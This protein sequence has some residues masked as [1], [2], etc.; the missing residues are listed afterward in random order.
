[1]ER[2]KLETRTGN[3]GA[4]LVHTEA[5]KEIR[6]IEMYTIVAIRMYVKIETAVCCTMHSVFDPM[7]RPCLV[8][9]AKVDLGRLSTIQHADCERGTP[10]QDNPST[11]YMR[12]G[13]S[14][15][16]KS[17]QED[18]QGLESVYLLQQWI[19]ALCYSAFFEDMPPKMGPSR[20]NVGLCF[21]RE[22]SA[23]VFKGRI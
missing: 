22:V 13:G 18:I 1:M 11:R 19:S 20:S 12:W 9:M 21:Q 2:G 7:L 14:S 16:K 8:C 10:I 5:C 4:Q 17:L 23:A 6:E 3:A 15:Y